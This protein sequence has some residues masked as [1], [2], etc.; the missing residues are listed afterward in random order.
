MFTAEA[1]DV[2]P[3][4]NVKLFA[5]IVSSL[6]DRESSI[7]IPVKSYQLGNMAFRAGTIAAVNVIAVFILPGACLICGLVIWLK[8]RRK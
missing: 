3:G 1:D 6:A 2:V 8:R 4:Y 5:N 7:A